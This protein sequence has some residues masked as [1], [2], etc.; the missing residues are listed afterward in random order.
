M[1]PVWPRL[2]EQP[3]VN[4]QVG[5]PRLHQNLTATVICIRRAAAAEVGLPKSGEFRF[6]TKPLKLTR[7]NTLKT[8][9]AVFNRSPFLSKGARNS[10]DQRRSSV[11]APVPCKLF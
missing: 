7:F 11:A 9:T 5:T 4:C 10:R 8:S 2:Q 6:P 3:P 1:Q